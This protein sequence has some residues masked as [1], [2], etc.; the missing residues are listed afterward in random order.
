MAPRTREG[1]GSYV[2]ERLK[3]SVAEGTSSGDAV[4]EDL[5][6]HSLTVDEYASKLESDLDFARQEVDAILAVPRPQQ[7]GPKIT[8]RELVALAGQVMRFIELHP[9]LPRE[10][11]L[12]A[13]VSGRPTLAQSFDVG[14]FEQIADTLRVEHR[15]PVRPPTQGELVSI[16]NEMRPV[17]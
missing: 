17:P 13:F 4:Y 7:E 3:Q 5:G 11:G 16:A 12:V 8:W 1:I 6:G 15:L 14:D 10:E 9:G 2:L